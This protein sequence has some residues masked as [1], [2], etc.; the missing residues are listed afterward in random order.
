MANVGKRYKAGKALIDIDK[1]YAADEAFSLVKEGNGAKFDETI[2]LAIR[3][4]VDPKQADQ[5]VRASVVLPNGTG[6]KVRIVV[7]AKGEKAR[8]AEAAG[9]D[10]VGEQ[11]IIDKIQKGWFDFDKLVATPDMMAAVGKIGSLLGPRGLMPNPKT[12]TV[13]MDIARAVEQIKAGKV[14]FRVDKTSNIHTVLG[15]RSFSK[16]QLTQN[17]NAI[18]DA[19]VKAKPSS[20]KGVYIKSV[21]VASTMGP[22]VRLDVASLV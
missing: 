10:F 19:I 18:M 11:D 5:M 7:L 2:D 1:L 6:K 14:D 15:K 17:L 20:S 22:G 9:A 16:E 21:V 8:E 4:G 12:G 3:L 13:T